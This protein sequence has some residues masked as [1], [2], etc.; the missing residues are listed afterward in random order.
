[1]KKKNGRGG[2]IRTHDLLYPKQ[3]RYQATLRPDPGQ[4][5]VPG[6]RLICNPNLCTTMT[7]DN[8][9][10]RRYGMRVPEFLTIC[11]RVK[12]CDPLRK[13]ACCSISKAPGLKGSGLFGTPP[14]KAENRYNFSH[15]RSSTQFA[16]RIGLAFCYG[17]YSI[18]AA[19]RQYSPHGV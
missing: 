12:L 5:K 4:Q 1:M 8:T 16:V 2:E 14:W 9:N 3:A 18:F 19:N 13:I 17:K 7:A 10:E 6:V 15:L 11:A